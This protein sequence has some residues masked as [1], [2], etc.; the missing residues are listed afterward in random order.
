MLLNLYLLNTLS[1]FQITHHNH[2]V[3]NDVYLEIFK[4]HINELLIPYHRL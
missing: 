4:E 1:R 3:S 2:I